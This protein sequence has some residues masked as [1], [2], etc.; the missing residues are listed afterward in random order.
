[1]AEE[2][3]TCDFSYSLLEIRFC[4]ITRCEHIF[5]I[6]EFLEISSF[7]CTETSFPIE[8]LCETNEPNKMET[9]NSNENR[10]HEAVKVARGK[11]SHRTSQKA[12]QEKR[13][14]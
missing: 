3:Q 11:L 10:K 4:L 8:T 5:F 14:K 12:S 6:E 7:F 13:C 2:G 1:M 9:E